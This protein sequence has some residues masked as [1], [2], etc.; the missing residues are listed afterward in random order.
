MNFN[1]LAK[2]GKDPGILSFHPNLRDQRPKPQ[3]RQNFLRQQIQDLLDQ[4]Y[5]YILENLHLLANK[6]L[7]RQNLSS[8]IEGDTFVNCLTVMLLLLILTHCHCY[9]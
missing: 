2:E 4:W 7:G 1:Y 5:H 8:R 6:I 3:L 9:Y